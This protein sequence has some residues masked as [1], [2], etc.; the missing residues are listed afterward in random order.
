MSSDPPSDARSSELE[1]A[2][3]LA[4]RVRARGTELLEALERHVPGARDHADGTAAY[5]FAAAVELELDRDHAEAV[6][7]TA[8]LHE[9]GCVYVPADVVAKPRGE[10]TTHEQALL[11]SAFASGAELARGAGI[12]DQVSDWIGATRERFDGSGPAGLAGERI[13]IE[14]R[15]IRVACACDTALAAP[16][17]PGTSQDELRRMAVNALRAAAGSELDPRITAAL[18]TM[19]ERATAAK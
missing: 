8:R 5:A 12:P 3:G 4:E 16:A 17:A 1:P 11:D 18:S 9:V 13:P 14:S 15:I 19:L 7:E 2:A 6:R 10:L